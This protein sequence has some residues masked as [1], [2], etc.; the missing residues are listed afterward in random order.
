MISR[1]GIAA[2]ILLAAPILGETKAEEQVISNNAPRPRVAVAAAKTTP[3]L[4]ATPDDP[5]WADAA[6]IPL[7][8]LSLSRTPSPTAPIPGTEI[9]LLWAPDWLYVRFLCKDDQTYLPSHQPGEPVF[10]GDAVEIFLDPVGDCREWIEVEINAKNEVYDQITL[11]TGEPKWDRSLRLTDDCIAREIWVLPNGALKNLRTAA[12]PWKV[13]GQT[14][15]WIVDAAIPAPEFLKRTGLKRFHTMT[16]R[17]DFLRYKSI[18]RA[19]GTGRDLLSLTWS[20]MVLG[21]PHRC[22]AAFGFI[23]L[24]APTP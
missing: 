21:I 5:A 23:N 10:H 13:N 19:S 22:P 2:M 18:P 1:I 4:T 7:N 12:A 11:C 14:V 17:G 20:P 9:R 16:L 8:T 24:S 15:G 6:P 3:T